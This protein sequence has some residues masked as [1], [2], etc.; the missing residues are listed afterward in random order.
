M[1]HDVERS[2]LPVTN[3]TTTTSSGASNATENSAVFQL[4]LADWAT[5]GEGVLIPFDRVTIIGHL[6]EGV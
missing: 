6:G 2:V 3:S 4:D 1:N 5:V